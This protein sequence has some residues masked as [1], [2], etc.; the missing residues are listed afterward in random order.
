MTR[1]E[2]I[3]RKIADEHKPRRLLARTQAAPPALTF[4]FFGF[5]PPNFFFVLGKS[6]VCRCA[7]AKRR[8][9]QGSRWFLALFIKDQSFVV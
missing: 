9:R 8:K 2:P 1:L 7:A 3:L 4:A 5:P 6:Q